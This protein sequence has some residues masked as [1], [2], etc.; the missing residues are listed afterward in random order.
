MIRQKLEC[1][2]LAQLEIIGSIYLS[3]PA[4]A[5]Q[6]DN[7]I[8]LAKDCA[9]NETGVVDRFVRLSGSLARIEAPGSSIVD[10]KAATRTSMESMLMSFEQEGQLK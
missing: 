5:Q 8:S 10:D 6:T 2:R 7:S 1:D 9:G 3:H 4:F